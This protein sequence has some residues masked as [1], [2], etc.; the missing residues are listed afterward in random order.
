LLR[1]LH[2]SFVLAALRARFRRV[3]P[4][5][6]LPEMVEQGIDGFICRDKS[7]ESLAEALNLYLTDPSL[8]LRQGS[9]AKKSLFRLGS[10]KFADNWLAVHKRSM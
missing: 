10:E 8:T 2:K 7:V 6:G 4:S 5:G 9:A 1:D 3:F